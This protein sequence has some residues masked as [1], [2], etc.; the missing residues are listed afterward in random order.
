MTAH[1]LPGSGVCLKVVQGRP[2]ALMVLFGLSLLNTVQRMAERH[3]TS[4][5][6]ERVNEALCRLLSNGPATLF[7]QYQRRFPRIPTAQP[8][9][10][11][12]DR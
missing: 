10:H 1:G 9:T 5:L 3:S 7:D 4:G 11:C 2:M 6:C 8:V 12:R